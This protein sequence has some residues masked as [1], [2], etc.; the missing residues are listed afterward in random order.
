MDAP[1]V[2]IGTPTYSGKEYVRKEFVAR[3]RELTYPHF[4]FLIVDNSKGTS[5][6]S[7][8]RRDGLRVAT[9][10]RGNNSRDA[11]RNAEN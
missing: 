6:A 11:L 8:L 1:K 2:L 9:V 7:K 4:D 10:P 5:Y 3:V